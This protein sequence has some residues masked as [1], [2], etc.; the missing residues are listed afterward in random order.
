M[1][2]KNWLV[3]GLALGLG[4]AVSAALLVFGNPAR[5]EVQ[6]YSLARDVAAGT[7]LGGDSLR[8][9]AALLPDGTASLFRQADAGELR[10]ALAGHDL[11]A[12]QLLQ[13]ADV[14]TVAA[15]ADIRLV[16]LP[17]KDAPPAA[18]G[19]KLDLLYITGPPDHPAVAPFALG[20]VVR[21]AV[22]GGFIV[23]VS[24]RRAA[25]YVYAAQAMQLVA[26]VATAGAPAGSEE[27]IGAPDQALAVASQP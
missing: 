5:D 4:I 11:V 8:L 2:M 22:T 24:S 12:G 16:F 26:I 1:R 10:G 9:V 25:A 18:P 21:A 6:V 23:A 17:V 13:R 27:P 14:V 7:S 3:A 15:S 19:S 20:V